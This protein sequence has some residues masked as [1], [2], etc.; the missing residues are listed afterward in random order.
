MKKIYIN[1]VNNTVGEIIK[2]DEG[3]YIINMRQGYID[4]MNHYNEP[5]FVLSGEYDKLPSAI[6]DR[7]P[8]VKS[9]MGRE[10]IKKMKAD[11]FT[12]IDELDLLAYSL[13]ADFSDHHYFVFRDTNKGDDYYAITLEYN[14][15]IGLY[16]TTTKSLGTDFTKQ[17]K[18]ETVRTWL[19][20][21]IKGNPHR[22]VYDVEVLAHIMLKYLKNPDEVQAVLQMENSF[23]N[24]NREVLRLVNQYGIDTVKNYLATSLG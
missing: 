23:L 10:L 16:W 5:P 2:T 4:W 7:I 3:K 11:G 24:L 15:K 8:A 21:Y 22:A 1:Y 13:G 6:R 18:Q 14:K 12:D 20:I 9:Y 17:A 19:D